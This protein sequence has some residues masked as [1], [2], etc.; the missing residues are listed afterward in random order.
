MSYMID[1]WPE[2]IAVPLGLFDA[3]DFSNPAYSIY[4]KNKQLWVTITSAETEHHP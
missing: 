3:A 1:G 4:E 2:V